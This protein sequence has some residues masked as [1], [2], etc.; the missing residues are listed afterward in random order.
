MPPLLLLL[1]SALNHSE[2]GMNI[3]KLFEPKEKR[4]YDAA[5]DG[6]VKVVHALLVKGTDI[7]W[8]DKVN[9]I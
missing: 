2:T 8:N 3:F 9:E 7:E 5:K 4:L 6:N 1:H